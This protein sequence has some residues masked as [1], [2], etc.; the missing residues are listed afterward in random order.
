MVKIIL[1]I[2]SFIS[3]VTVNILADTLPI[4]NQTSEAISNRIPA[5]FTPAN[6]AFSILIL[7]YI[8]LAFW[9][10][11]VIREYRIT[12]KIPWNRVLLFVASCIF[13]IAWIFFWHYELFSYS[14]ITIIALLW[15]FFILYMT[16]S[17]EEENWKS[18]VPIS[19]YLG[20]T[21]VATITN[22]DF[23]LTYY[24]FGGFGM[25]TSLWVVIFMTIATAIALHF[26]YHYNDR[27]I[28]LVFIWAFIGIA[29]RHKFDDLLITSASLFLSSVL[30][31][32]ILVIKKTPSKR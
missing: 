11:N 24:E 6:Y 2:F 7:I 4:N 19:I 27:A 26:R 17:T 9:L 22:L 32:G 13:N 31:V 1:L 10:W 5:L 25:T 18:R 28:V 30:L 16:Y 3:T 14:L 12:S 23:V 8:L 20:W 21:F 29:A 15:T